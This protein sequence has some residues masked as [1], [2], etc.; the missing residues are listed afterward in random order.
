LQIYRKAAFT[1]VKGLPEE[2]PAEKEATASSNSD[3]SEKPVPLEEGV[4]DSPAAAAEVEAAKEAAQA[5]AKQDPNAPA[6]KEPELQQSGER[7]TT[8]TV[9][10]GMKVPDNVNVVIDSKNLI[11]Y[12]GPPVYQ[13][14]RIYT[15]KSP[16][17]VSTGLGYLGNGSGSVSFDD[18]YLHTATN[19]LLVY[20]QVMPIEVTVMPGSGI[21]LTGKLGEVIKESAQIAISFMKAHAHTLQLTSDP[22]QDLLEK[23][24]VHL[25]MP[26]GSIGKEGPSA[27]TAILT[28]L[29]SLFTKQGIDS[30]IALTGE[31]T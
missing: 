9:R 30:S 17:G 18:R 27:G 22:M 24:A 6:A 13:R 26:E 8:T 10:K 7:M 12:V 11:D 2:A 20:L 29:V 16:P 4:P 1:I 3:K 5:E 25:H 14:E 23:K 15:K 19:L 28:A 31:M 21:Q